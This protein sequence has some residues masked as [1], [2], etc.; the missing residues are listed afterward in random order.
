MEIIYFHTF[1]PFDSKL[2]KSSVNKTKKLLSVEEL[3]AHDGLFNQC[4]KS[5]AE[6]DGLSLKQLAVNDFVSGYGSHQ[7]MMETAQISEKYIIKAA[8]LLAKKK[9]KIKNY[10][11]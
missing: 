6:L 3:S 7:D 10:Y 1:K 2:L 9:L 4:L 5:V 11:E 8:K